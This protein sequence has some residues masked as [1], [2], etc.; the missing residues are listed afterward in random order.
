MKKTFALLLVFSFVFAMAFAVEVEERSIS[1]KVVA[2]DAKAGTVSVK[3]DEGK[4]NVLKGT[5]EQL[6]KIKVGDDVDVVVD[7]DKIISIMKA[8]EELPE[9]SPM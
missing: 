1:G 6:E 7:G 3:D 2:V 4:T 5:K 8:N 9:E